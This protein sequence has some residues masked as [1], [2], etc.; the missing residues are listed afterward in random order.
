M[1]KK[2]GDSETETITENIYVADDIILKIYVHSSISTIQK[3]H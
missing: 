2:F 1:W 3:H